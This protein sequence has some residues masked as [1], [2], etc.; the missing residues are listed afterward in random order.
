MS[1]TTILGPAGVARVTLFAVA[2]G[3]A[4]TG[5]GGANP[6]AAVHDDEAREAPVL[7]SEHAPPSEGIVH[8]TQHVDPRLEHPNDP[9]WGEFWV[10]PDQPERD[11]PLTR[12]VLAAADVRPGMVVADVGAGGGYYALQFAR[13]SQPLGMVWAVDVDER[14]VRAL[15]WLR[16]S[17]GVHNLIPL[18]VPYGSFG[19]PAHTFDLVTLIEVGAFLTCESQRAAGYVQ[20]VARALEPG[21]RW[22]VV[23]R[24]DGETR[25]GS[26]CRYYTAAEVVEAAREHFH[27]VRND[28]VRLGP[29]WRGFVL[30]LARNP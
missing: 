25:S 12:A 19:L 8:L 6:R 20:Q 10:S 22:L 4:G 2:L 26:A 28:E 18:H 7:V 1:V 23:N 24:V 30:V 5:D 13:A 29:H 17:R 15:S 21:G 9:I 27:V 3:L 11:N 14:M 16:T